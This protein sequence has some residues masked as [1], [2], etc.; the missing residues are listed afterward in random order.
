MLTLIFY[1][2]DFYMNT[3]KKIFILII[4]L[5]TISAISYQFGKQK[6][7]SSIKNKPAQQKEKLTCPYKIKGNKFTH[8]YKLTQDALVTEEPQLIENPKIIKMNEPFDLTEF[9]K[10]LYKLSTDKG[11]SER[12]FDVDNDGKE[13]RI[14]SANTAMNH[15]PHIALI[16]KDGRI[17]F[18]AEGANVWIDRDHQGRGFTLSKTI[19]WNIGE[20]ETIRYLPK[21]GGFIPIWK[22]KSCS[23]YFE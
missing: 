12:K 11:W 7:I 5:A 20:K 19:D 8:Q 15:T 23:V 10:K 13:E 16:L 18:K 14:I 9:E 2:N 22:Q 3:Y 21:D 4:L 17:V 1:Y 6:S